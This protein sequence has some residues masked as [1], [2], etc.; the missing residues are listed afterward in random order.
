MHKLLL[1]ATAILLNLAT[2]SANDVVIIPNTPNEGDFTTVTTVTTGNPVTTN[3]L[4]SQ[5]FS[6]GT[7]NGTMYPDNSDINESTWLTGKHGKYA[8][9]TINSEDYVSIE[10]MQQGFSSDFGAQIRW[11]NQVESEVTMTQTISN[12]VDTTTQST[13]FQDTTNHNYQLNPYGNQLV[14]GADPNM[15]HG[16]LTL[17]FDFNIIGNQSFNG[18]HSGVDVTDPTLIIDYT[19]LSSTTISEVTYCWQQSPPTCPGQEQIEDVQEA[20]ENIDTVIADFVMPEELIQTDYFDYVPIEIEYSFNDVFEED[21]EIEDNF[22]IIP[23]NEFFFEDD[24]FEPEY[25]EEFVVEDFIPEDIVMVETLDWNDSNVEIFDELPSLDMFEELPPLEEVY[26]EDIIMEEEMFVETFTEEMQEEFID[27]VY[28]EVMI[29]TTPEPMPDPEPEPMEEIQEVAMVQ[30]EPEVVEEQPAMEEIQEEPEPIQEEIVD[31]QIEEQPNSEEVVA[32]EPEPTTEI[33]EQEEA[34]EEPIEAEPTEV[35]ETTEPE[36]SEPVEIDLDI[37]VAAIEKAIQAKVSNEMQR[38]S[39]T[40]DVVNEIVSREM[41]AEQADISSYFNTNAALFDSRQLPSGD[42]AFFKQMS[43][44]TYN[45][46]IYNEQVAM[47][48]DMVG[49]DPV[50]QYD[51]KIRDI[52][53]RKTKIFIELKEMLNARSN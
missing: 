15:T 4:I 41:T 19:A 26:M 5:D 45:Y 49:Q 6:D 3:N 28:E 31:E 44:D 2:S 24:Y 7:W 1:T 9:T 18:G 25:Y 47:V 29:E 39:M 35:A 42:P 48:T 43:L 50:V 53:S 23:M 16:T 37:K 34:V 33:A 8:E 27:E 46:T 38:V 14:V 12:G 10:E 52:N 51:N 17:R 32:D 22:D 40:L 20:I 11:W 21:I 30:E 36:S 13:T